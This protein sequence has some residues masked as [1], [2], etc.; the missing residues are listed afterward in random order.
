MNNVLLPHFSKSVLENRDDAFRQLFKIL[1][2][3]FVA[4][5]LIAIA[6]IITSDFFVSLFFERNEFTAQDSTLVSGLQKIILLYIPFKISG[7]LLVN[8]LTS[9]NKNS[10]M[11]IVSFVSIVLNIILNFSLVKPYGV[12]GI[13]IATT[14]VVI[15]RN[16]LL[17][18][19]TKIQKNKFI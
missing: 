3:V 19:F 5:S 13:A 1:K 18:H 15:L 7:M 4:S 8:F 10:Y 6:G 12:F 2:V 16:L 14:I 17:F 11:A 9:I